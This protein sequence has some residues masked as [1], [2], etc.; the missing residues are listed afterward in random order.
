MKAKNIGS[1]QCHT[2]NTLTNEFEGTMLSVNIYKSAWVFYTLRGLSVGQPV[3]QRE[4]YLQLVEA[5]K[6]AE[7]IQ[8]SV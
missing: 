1:K 3:K 4:S 2:W 5:L 7:Y 6:I 8:A